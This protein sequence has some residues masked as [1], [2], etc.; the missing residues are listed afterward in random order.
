MQGGDEMHGYYE[1]LLEEAESIN[2]LGFDLREIAYDFEYKPLLIGGKALEYYGVRESDH[3]FDF[4]I[5]PDDYDRL[6][7][8]YA[9]HRKEI[10]GDLGVSY[11]GYEFWKSICMLDY[12]FYSEGA[13]EE[14]D[15]RVISFEK[16]MFMK[17]LTMRVPKCQRDLEL[18]RD[19]MA[20]INTIYHDY[21]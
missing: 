17:V 5:H 19:R 20:V 13:V 11:H 4:L 9:D 18:M 12:D 3:D 16:L 14:E 15:L 1:I 2:R 8:K 7:M 21:Y 6:A 10:S